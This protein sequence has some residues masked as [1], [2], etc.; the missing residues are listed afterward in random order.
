MPVGGP[1]LDGAGNPIERL[2]LVEL[3]TELKFIK[4][5]LEHERQNREK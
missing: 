5:N 2:A 3:A 4:E 1:P